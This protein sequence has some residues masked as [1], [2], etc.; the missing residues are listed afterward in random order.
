[1]LD[2]EDGGPVL[3]RTVG[4]TCQWTRR[5]RA[6]QFNFQHRSENPV[7]RDSS[8]GIATRYVLHGPGIE[9]QWRQYFLHPSRAHPA[10]Y[11]MGT[12]SFPGV[13]R[14]GRGVALTTHPHLALRLKKE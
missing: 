5:S 10:S 1:V 3:L 2:S 7:D 8:V 9:S 4:D 11:A 14:P 6:E 12:G 13:K